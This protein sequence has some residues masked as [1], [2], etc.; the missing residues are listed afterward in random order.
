MRHLRAKAANYKI[1]PDRIGMVGFCAGAMTTMSVVR[2]GDAKD[3]PDFATTIYGA[4]PGGRAPE[5]VPPLFYCS[6]PA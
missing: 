1:D 3:I 6:R 2:E 4:M 5:K